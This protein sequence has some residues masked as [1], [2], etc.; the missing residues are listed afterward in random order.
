MKKLFSK[1]RLINKDK[2]KFD[3]KFRFLLCCLILFMSFGFQTI[4]YSAIQTTSLITGDAYVRVD[5]DIRITHFSVAEVYNGGI[6][7]YEEYSKDTLQTHVSL[8][9]SNSYVK[10]KIVV[11][12][13]GDAEMAIA[14]MINSGDSNSNLN[15]TLESIGLNE[16]I[17]DD[18]DSKLCSGGA[19]RTFYLKVSYNTYNASS[20]EYTI[21]MNLV[22]DYAPSP[23]AKG[24]VF[25][26]KISNRNIT[27]IIFTNESPPSGWD[28]VPLA[29]NGTPY[30]VG[31][32]DDGTF[33]VSNKRNNL[34]IEANVDCSYMFSNLPY[35]IS[36]NLNTLS[37]SET[38]NMEGAFS[39]VATST[40]STYFNLLNSRNISGSNITNMSHLF[41][42]SFTNIGEVAIDL[43]GVDVSSVT[44]MSYM[45][46]NTGLNSDIVSLNLV[47][48][49]TGSLTNMSHMFENFGKNADYIDVYGIDG[50][51]T[52]NVTNMNST[53]KYMG[54]NA[55][56]FNI[57]SLSYW[58]T[59]NVTDMSYMF[60][61]AGY[62]SSDYTYIGDGLDK[63]DTSKVTTMTHMFY[64]YGRNSSN[65][66]VGDL[67]TKLVDESRTYAAWDTSNV[68]D[69]SYMFGETAYEMDLFS[70]GDIGTW[71]TSK[72]TDMSYMFMNAGRGCFDFDTLDLGT[73]SLS[74]PYSSENYTAW[75]VSNV[76]NMAHMFDQYG[77][78]AGYSKVV[79]NIQNWN[80]EKVTDMSYMFNQLHKTY[81][82][83]WILNLSG[84]NVKNVTNM[85]YMFYEV[86]GTNFGG[87]TTP[88]N[89]RTDVIKTNIT[90]FILYECDVYG[91]PVNTYYAGDFPTGNTTYK[92][93][94]PY[95][96]A[97]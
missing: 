51:Y 46:Y 27:E 18:N 14:E 56:T 31:W 43:G 6:S 81:E 20:T 86:G 68:T 71:N 30:I 16:K 15:Y 8:L 72:V 2:F 39:N 91:E 40:N 82:K 65:W 62:N 95:L 42:G 92:E 96:A 24:S 37:F 57:G 53:F 19:T 63:W 3:N 25:N 44:D 80:V 26:S 83:F 29:E 28:T 66:Y 54:S 59:S 11:R 48:I 7:S 97:G 47:E 21:N 4:A 9:N 32:E 5:G 41:D 49:Y 45:F 88:Y 78:Y 73:K 22:F 34:D 35:L 90:S 58:D 55:L 77:Y 75:D 69:M 13:Y 70:L 93:L 61:G 36:I 64:E 74:N 33:Y 12:N 17:C 10:Y 87:I 76:T 1:T 50:L 67:S 89:I 52:G 94:T 38:V 60:N 85:S 84:W 23:L 79:T